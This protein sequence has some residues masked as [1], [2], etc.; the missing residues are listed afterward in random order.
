MYLDRMDGQTI[1]A[2]AARAKSLIDTYVGTRRA[3]SASVVVLIDDYNRFT[4]P[5]ASW[6]TPEAVQREVVET[7]ERHGVM[8][9]H[10][11]WEGSLADTVER[12]FDLLVPEP[13]R[14]DGSRQ[15]STEEPLWQPETGW[16][17][18]GDAGRPRESEFG[19]GVLMATDEA[20]VL[21]FR[22]SAPSYRRSIALDVQLWSDDDG[23][24]VWACPVLAAWWQLVRLG[25]LQHVSGEGPQMPANTWSRPGGKPL[26]AIGTITFLTSDY[27]QVEHAVWNILRQVSLPT[28]WANSLRDSREQPLP[29]AHLERMAYVFTAGPGTAFGESG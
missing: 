7:F 11:V 16:L 24:R 23:D 8:L 20:A 21:S 12:M 14:G 1:E 22:S 25:A 5:R 29:R 26:H 13:R 6:D 17:S 27:I 9:D 2:D 3:K 18:N 28:D 10:V 19:G 4:R 15:G